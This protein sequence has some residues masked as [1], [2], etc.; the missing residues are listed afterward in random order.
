MQAT[1]TF[2]ILQSVQIGSAGKRKSQQATAAW[3]S[4]SGQEN[5]PGGVLQGS[6]A[7][8]KPWT[9]WAWGDGAEA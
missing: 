9:A 7:R 1:E 2:C 8:V 3:D 6:G 4:F 5:R